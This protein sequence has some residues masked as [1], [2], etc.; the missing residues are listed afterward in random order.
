VTASAKAK[1]KANLKADSAARSEWLAQLV[2]AASGVVLAVIVYEL[3]DLR[4]DEQ[5]LQ[6]W[7]AAARN[8]DAQQ[9]RVLLA[10]GAWPE[11]DAVT[12][13]GWSALHYAAYLGHEEVVGVLLEAGADPDVVH[14]SGQT[15]LHRVA[16]DR[17]SVSIARELIAR[18][19]TIDAVARGRTPLVVALG[20][21]NFDL[22]SYLLDQ[23][24]RVQFVEPRSGYTPLL[25][26]VRSGRSDLASMLLE[27]GADIG[28]Q[29]QNGDTVLHLAIAAESPDSIELLVAHG[30]DPRVANARGETALQLAERSQDSALVAALLGT[31]PD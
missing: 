26:A 23:G 25:Y 8:G 29:L 2:W 17:G 1:A 7:I 12:Q 30:A 27:R 14:P 4:S 11:L 6:E 20:S 22:A 3:V 15:P 31:P 9:V 16:T 18:G 28:A 13:D 24:A 10:A 19:A 21:R 5:R